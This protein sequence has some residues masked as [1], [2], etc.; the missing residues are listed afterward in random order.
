MSPLASVTI[1]LAG[2][3][4]D[5][6]TTRCSHNFVTVSARPG[7]A[8][9]ATAQTASIKVARKRKANWVIILCKER[10]RRRCRRRGRA[11]ERVGKR[12]STGAQGTTAGRKGRWR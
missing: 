4:G 3:F 7:S 10:D 5:I 11:G 12:E 6:P 2:K 9:T 1:A 8:A